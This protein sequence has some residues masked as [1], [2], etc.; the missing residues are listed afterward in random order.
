MPTRQAEQR[1]T[2]APRETTRRTSAAASPSAVHSAGNQALQRLLR[3]RFVQAKLHVSHPGDPFEVEAD[4]VADAVL[5]APEGIHRVCQECEEEKLQRSETE[6]GVPEV[7]PALESRI[8]SL[9][10]SGQP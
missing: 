4:R 2:A 6:A 1:I 10:G 8:Q 3:G 5:Q 7:T 9:R